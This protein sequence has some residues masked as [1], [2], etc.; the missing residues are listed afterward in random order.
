MTVISVG[1]ASA[2]LKSSS[3]AGETPV[4]TLLAGAARTVREVRR[5][6]RMLVLTK[7]ISE[8]K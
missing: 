3:I 1:E 7:T 5:S 6:K 4:S 2:G 8:R